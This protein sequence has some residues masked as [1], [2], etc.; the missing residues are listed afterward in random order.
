MLFQIL[1]IAILI[2]GHS[3]SYHIPDM[4]FVYEQLK[5]ENDNSV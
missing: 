2:Q 4:F 3:Y 5:F 1:K